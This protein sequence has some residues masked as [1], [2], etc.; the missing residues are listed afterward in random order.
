MA[1]PNGSPSLNRRHRFDNAREGISEFE[2][3]SQLAFSTFG[4]AGHP[5]P[6]VD[7][8][9]RVNDADRWLEI[10]CSRDFVPCQERGGFLLR[11]VPGNIFAA[12]AR[13]I[14]DLQ[15]DAAQLGSAAGAPLAA[16]SE[17]AGGAG[18][19]RSGGGT[20]FVLGAAGGST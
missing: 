3:L 17:H 10:V 19:G 1:L 4:N 14:E 9:Y 2:R 8:P 15:A 12:S 6:L 20:G 18:S 7:V 16:K 13:A 11:R 5:D